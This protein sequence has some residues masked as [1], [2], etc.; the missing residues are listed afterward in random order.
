[1]AVG[2]KLFTCRAVSAFRERN[3]LPEGSMAKRRW[4][5]CVGSAMIFLAL[6]TVLLV[7]RASR[8]G[9]GQP[10]TL[11]AER[12]SRCSREPDDDGEGDDGLSDGRVEVNQ[13]GPWEVE[14]PQLPQ[15]K[16]YF[17]GL[18]CEGV[19]VGPP[20]QVSRDCHPKEAA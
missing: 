19:D 20:L 3:L 2:K 5:G 14:F 10:I 15:E 7:N 1:M 8:E 17:L 12:I 16:Q 9:K 11:S 18:L 6:P 13:H 4:P